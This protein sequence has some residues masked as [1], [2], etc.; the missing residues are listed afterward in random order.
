MVHKYET[1]S[2]TNTGWGIKISHFFRRGIKYERSHLE[3][4]IEYISEKFIK[5]SFLMDFKNQTRHKAA[6]VGNTLLKTFP[7][8]FH[9]SPG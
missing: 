9:N 5:N 3:K 2:R 1:L 7:E 6:V 4:K 8:A